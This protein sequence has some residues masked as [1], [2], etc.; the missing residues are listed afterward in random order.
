MEGPPFAE[1][2]NAPNLTHRVPQLNLTQLRSSDTEWKKLR[3]ILAENR[4]SLG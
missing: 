2:R 3:Q 4:K 1:S